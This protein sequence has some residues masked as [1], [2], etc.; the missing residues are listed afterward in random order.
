[1]SLFVIVCT[2]CACKVQKSEIT[3]ENASVCH[4]L[5]SRM[6]FHTYVNHFLLG[7]TKGDIKY[8][9]HA[10]VFQRAVKGP[11]LCYFNVS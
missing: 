3:N 5:I 11:L 7:N 10:A 1:M 9:V 2:V 8:N 4:H 6:L